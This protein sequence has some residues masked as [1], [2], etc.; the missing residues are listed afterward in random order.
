MLLKRFVNRL[1]RQTRV[2][3]PQPLLFEWPI[4]RRVLSHFEGRKRTWETRGIQGE[5]R[6]GSYFEFGCYNGDTLVDFV[7]V[8]KAQYPSGFPRY[9]DIHVFDSFEGLPPT[10]STADIHPYAGEGSYKSEGAAAVQSRILDL[11]FPAAKLS[12]YEGFY[13][14]T[15]TESL[16]T[17]LQERGVVASF[18]NVDCD[19]YSST[20]TVLDWIEPLLIDGSIIYFDDIYFYN[21]NPHKGELKAIHDF[22]AART[23]SGLALAP[24]FDRGARCYMYWRNEPLE[25]RKFVFE[26]YVTG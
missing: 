17:R 20:K 7:N 23:E 26:K 8:L 25:P 5:Y 4:L 10:T 13:E 18:V 9:W 22:N 12:L 14:D 6:I 16:R 19:Y 15:L 2:A 3:G 21:C 1:R 11:G 24:W